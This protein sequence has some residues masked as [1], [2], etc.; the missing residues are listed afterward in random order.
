[1]RVWPLVLMAG[2]MCVCFAASASAM[3]NRTVC[4]C[5]ASVL[6]A[7]RVL[8]PLPGEEPPAGAGVGHLPGWVPVCCQACWLPLKPCIWQHCSP[9]LSAVAAT[10]LGGWVPGPVFARLVVSTLAQCSPGLHCPA[11]PSAHL[12]LLLL[13]LAALLCSFRRGCREWAPLQPPQLCLPGAVRI[14][15]QG[16]P[17]CWALYA[18]MLL[19]RLATAA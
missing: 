16:E 13:L 9:A 3:S 10:F 6:P 18:A 1:L 14:H 5:T 11:L 17:T 19:L 15:S 4:P 8:Q 12:L 7:G 2:C